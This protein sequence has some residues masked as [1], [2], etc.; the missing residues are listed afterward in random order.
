LKPKCEEEVSNVA[1]NFNVRRC[2]EGDEAAV[3]QLSDQLAQVMGKLHQK[4]DKGGTQAVMANINK[5]NNQINDTN[6]SASAKEAA[7]YTRPLF[8]ST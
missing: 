3:E 7:A 8:S 6:M 1:F 2:N 4:L 5:R